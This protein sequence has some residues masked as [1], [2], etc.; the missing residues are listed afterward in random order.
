MVLRPTALI[1]DDDPDTRA[2]MLRALGL[3]GFDVRAFDDG[4]ILAD[5]V[6]ATPPDLVVTDQS[7]VRC[8][9]TAA[10]GRIRTAGGLC[11]AVLVTAFPSSD[12][13]RDIAGLAPC[14]LIPKPL[15]L[16]ALRAALEGL[17]LLR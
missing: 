11:P 6:L 14:V 5:A 16:R 4:D 9:G 17:G 8:D 7:M 10:L 3:F 15:D 13:E 2:L 1:A 12:L